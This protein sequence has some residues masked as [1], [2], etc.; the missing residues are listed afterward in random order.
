MHVIKMYAREAASELR[1]LVRSPQF[2]VPTLILPVGSFAIS[3]SFAAANR[4]EALLSMM[5]AFSIMAALGPALFGFGSGIATEREA[6]LLDL[7]R[8]SPLPATAYLAAKLAACMTATA[9]SI[10]AILVIGA[11]HHDGLAWWRWPLLIA[12]GSTSAVPFTLVG[13]SIGLRFSA[14]A[15]TAMSNVLLLAFT[16]LGGMLIPVAAL[17]TPLGG[18]SEVLPTIH[19]GRLALALLGNVGGFGYLDAVEMLTFTS[20]F[21]AMALKGWHRPVA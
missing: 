21:A 14:Q 7:K 2:L 16:A 6:G 19:F 17:P 10:C 11:L 3:A 5:A 20:V 12:A 1:K 4:T 15:A 18:V 8:V 13:L 9:I